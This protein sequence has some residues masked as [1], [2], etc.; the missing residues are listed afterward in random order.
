MKNNLTNIIKR[1]IEEEFGD[2]IEPNKLI[3]VDYEEFRGL[4]MV[5]GYSEDISPIDKKLASKELKK[6]KTLYL[7][8]RIVIEDN[9]IEVTIQTTG[10]M[11]L[12]VEIHK[13]KGNIFYL[14]VTLPE[15][16]WNQTE[17]YK[18]KS[19]MDVLMKKVIAMI[20]MNVKTD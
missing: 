12:H 4:L 11:N 13:A 10:L 16:R 14:K 1:I 19:T 2:E 3:K 6:L 5:G 7:S 15:H 8:T 17:Y 18:I 9:F 20:F